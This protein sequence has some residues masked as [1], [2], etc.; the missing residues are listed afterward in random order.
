MVNGIKP[1]RPRFIYAENPRIENRNMCNCAC[2]EKGIEYV[3][4]RDVCSICAKDKNIKYVC[5]AGARVCA[6]CVLRSLKTIVHFQF[7]KMFE[8]KIEN[9]V[10][11][12]GARMLCE[13][14]KYN[15]MMRYACLYS[16]ML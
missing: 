3:Y 9:F 13:N 15:M 7:F 11:V 14:A 10:F 12:R 8:T 1:R 2:I 16:C 6:V 5:G 4:A